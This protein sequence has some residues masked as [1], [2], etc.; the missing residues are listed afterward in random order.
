MPAYKVLSE[1]Y[2]DGIYRTP[3]GDHDPVI[4]KKKLNPCPAW[5]EYLSDVTCVDDIVGYQE[6]NK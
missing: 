1:G 4:T 2:H 6:R 3:D 5:L